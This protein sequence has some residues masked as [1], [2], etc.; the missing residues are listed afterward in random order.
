MLAR[1]FLAIIALLVVACSPVVAG[2]APGS[3][4]DQRADRIAT[5]A[6]WA[7]GELA[8][9]Y[10]KHPEGYRSQSDYDQGARDTIREGVAFTYRDTQSDTPRLGYYQR[11]GNRFTALTAD[12]RRITTHFRPDRGESYVRGLPGSSYR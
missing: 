8:E 1:W 6:V 3:A 10:K 7:S 5:S 4:R 2:P 11:D 12:G 9:H